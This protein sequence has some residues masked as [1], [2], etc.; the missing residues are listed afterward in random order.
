M[1]TVQSISSEVNRLMSVGLTTSRFSSFIDLPGSVSI[2]N[3]PDT[4]LDG[5]VLLEAF[6][7]SP[8]DRWIV[9]HYFGMV[10]VFD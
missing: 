8:F 5:K 7:Q 10:L 2:V 1:K 6:T 4:V 9:G 3:G